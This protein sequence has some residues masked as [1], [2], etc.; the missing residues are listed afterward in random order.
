MKN[1]CVAVAANGKK[2]YAKPVVE[3]VNIDAADIICGSGDTY[4]VTNPF[5][6][7]TEQPW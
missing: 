7:N 1:Q 6:G 3:V 2:V 4:D 5:G